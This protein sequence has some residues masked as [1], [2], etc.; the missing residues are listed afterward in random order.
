[1]TNVDG[2]RMRQARHDIEWHRKYILALSCLVLFLVGASLGALVG[3]GGLGLPTILALLVF[4]LYYVLSMVGEQMV[5]VGTLSPALGMW[6]STLLLAPA[7]LLLFRLAKREV[8][9]LHLFRSK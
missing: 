8:T 5:K 3:R 6:L 4:L 2:K 7:A 9:W 1:M